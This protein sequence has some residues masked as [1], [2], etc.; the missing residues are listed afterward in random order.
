M[1]GQP[2]WQLVYECIYVAL[3]DCPSCHAMNSFL[4]ILIASTSWRTRRQPQ[5]CSP[6]G[7]ISGYL[8]LRR[9]S[10]KALPSSPMKPGGRLLAQVV[11]PHR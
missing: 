2:R 3:T 4:Y 10:T 1:L 8:H 6:G 7:L 5:I 9:C 11:N